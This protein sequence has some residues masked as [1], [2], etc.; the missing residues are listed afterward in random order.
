V[1]GSVAGTRL[2][3]S[4][5]SFPALQGIRVQAH[6]VQQ[7]WQVISRIRSSFSEI[8]SH[9]EAGTQSGGAWVLVLLVRRIP[10]IVPPT[11]IFQ[12]TTW[13]RRFVCAQ[14]RRSKPRFLRIQY[15]LGTAG[16]GA[17]MSTRIKVC[18]TVVWNKTLA[19]SSQSRRCS[20]TL[21]AHGCDSSRSGSG[22]MTQVYPSSRN[23]FPF[24]GFRRTWRQW[25]MQ[26]G[27]LSHHGTRQKQGSS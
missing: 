27:R 17:G 22:R 3:I 10:P 4:T 16:V 5:K 24:P 2:A 26:S 11:V 14:A 6:I 15:R 1:D 23:M 8:H 13:R 25:C 7:P 19:R 12:L 20:L 18:R 21:A 9:R